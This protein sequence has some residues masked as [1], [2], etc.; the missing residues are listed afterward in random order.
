MEASGKEIQVEF[1]DKPEEIG[2]TYYR[3][4]V[5][6]PASPFPEVPKST[7]ISKNMVGLSNPIYFNFDPS[8]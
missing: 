8:F 1:R 4:A 6:G 5:E 2:R 3:I 7:S